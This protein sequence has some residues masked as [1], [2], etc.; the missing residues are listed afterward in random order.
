MPDEGEILVNGT[1]VRIGHPHDAIQ[2]GIGMVHQHFKLVPSFTIAENI[3]LGIE[4]NRAGFIDGAAEAE[5]VRR[6]LKK[7]WACQLTR[8][9]A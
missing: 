3:M 7:F 2:Q 9:P 4:P 8:M 1:P 5:N 6:W